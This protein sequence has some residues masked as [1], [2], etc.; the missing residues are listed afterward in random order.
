M[1]REIYQYAS[2]EADLLRQSSVVE[3][4]RQYQD[5]AG[6][7]KQHYLLFYQAP[8]GRF[9]T[10]TQHCTE[11]EIVNHLLSVTKSLK[12]RRSVILPT[13]TDAEAINKQKDLWTYVI[14][15]GSLMYN[16]TRLMTQKVVYQEP[17]TKQQQKWSPF[18]G[19]VPAGSQ[20]R[21]FGEL[22]VSEVA[23]N[24][25]MP[26][27]FCYKC[28]SWLYRDPKAFNTALELA[29]T[30]ALS[31]VGQLIIGAHRAKNGEKPQE[32][33]PNLNPHPKGNT[34]NEHRDTVNVIT[35]NDWLKDAILNTVFSQFISETIDG[36]V[37][38]DPEIFINY[39]N[40]TNT[41]NSYEIERSSFIAL[42][43]HKTGPQMKFNS[44][45]TK[46]TLLISDLSALD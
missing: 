18:L 11:H 32:Q 23:V 19:P 43:I 37:I 39:C 12:L 27:V 5:L 35:F 17:K 8:L 1:N 46:P 14:F 9:L 31:R 21:N 2:S 13:A 10:L 16:S 36:Y 34:D 30:P 20:Y 4:S 40:S 24:T 29:H 45:R 6:L 22:E 3:I 15:V 25:L 26:L 41:T 44:G 7:P 42:G 33:K 38:S 28:I